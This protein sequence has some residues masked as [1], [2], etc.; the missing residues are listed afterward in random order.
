MPYAETSPEL[1]DWFLY[2]SGIYW[3]ELFKLIFIDEWRGDFIEF[4]V[5]HLAAVFLVFGYS[6]T[7]HTPIGTIISFIHLISDVPCCLVKCLG[8]THYDKITVVIF[9]GSHM[10][11]WL[12]WRLICL[13][14]WII[15][16]F[17]DPVC[18]YNPYGHIVFKYDIFNQIFGIYLA[19]LQ[20]LQFYWFW[21]FIQ[22]VISATKTGEAEDHQEKVKVIEKTPGQRKEKDQ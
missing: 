7:N 16:I 10:T 19:V 20:F 4:L 5:H 17:T 11:T 3:G 21:M 6:F 12:Y 9:A 2:S 8:S 22:M 18:A 15:P 1:Y 13:P 14:L